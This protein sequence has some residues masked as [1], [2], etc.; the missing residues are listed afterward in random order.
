MMTENVKDHGKRGTKTDGMRPAGGDEVK[1]DTVSF[2]CWEGQN[3]R[4][5]EA[6]L[7]DK[8]PKSEW[9]V[10]ALMAAADRS[11]GERGPVFPEMRRRPVKSPGERLPPSDLIAMWRGLQAENNAIRLELERL[12]E[13]TKS[14]PPPATSPLSGS[15]VRRRAANRPRP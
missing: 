6:A 8:L 12:R 10:R 15:G 4:I 9:M 14:V 7:R 3:S 13:A 2:R 11:L 1:P 5:E